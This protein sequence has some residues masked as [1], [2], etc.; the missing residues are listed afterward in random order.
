MDPF[1]DPN[2]SFFMVSYYQTLDIPSPLFGN[3]K[4]LRIHPTKNVKAEF[5]KRPRL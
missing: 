3:V 1:T 4:Y 2:C 5:F